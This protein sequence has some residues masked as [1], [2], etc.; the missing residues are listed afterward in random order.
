MGTQQ[1]EEEPLTVNAQACTDQGRASLRTPV[2]I[3]I[4]GVLM[5]V[6]GISFVITGAAFF[7]MGLET[8][9]TLGVPQNGLSAVWAEVGAAAGVTFLLFGGLHAILAV[10]ILRLRNVARVLTI[11]LFALSAAGAILGLV[12]AS[13]RFNRAS[14]EWNLCLVVADVWVPWYLLCPRT[15]KAFGA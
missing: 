15:K 9:D 14:L 4:L 3:K 13:V 12:A 1:V 5:V 11:F 10:G 6:A 8:A 7:F 2:G